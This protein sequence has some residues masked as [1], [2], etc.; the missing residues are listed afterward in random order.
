MSQEIV[1]ND[2]FTYLL[3]LPLFLLVAMPAAAQK[4]GLNSGLIPGGISNI[5]DYRPFESTNQFNSRFVRDSSYVYEAFIADSIEEWLLT[6]RTLHYY[7]IEGAETELV[8]SIFNGER[9]YLSE[10][11]EFS[12]RS[13]KDLEKTLINVWS[14]DLQEW[15][16]HEQLTYNYT[17]EGKELEVLT[18]EWTVD[19][20][21]A[22]SL[23][24][25]FYGE[26]NNLETHITSRW[27]GA[28]LDWVPE[29][30][31][32]Y[33]YEEDSDLPKT[34]RLQTWS[35]SL[36]MWINEIERT[37][38]YDEDD[39]IIEAL[40]STW[41]SNFGGF[42]PTIFTEWAYNSDGQQSDMFSKPMNESDSAD[43]GPT[44]NT[45]FYGSSAIY[46]DDG[47]LNQLVTRE[48]DRETETW[49]PIGYEKHFWSQHRSGSA[50]MTDPDITCIYANPHTIGLPWYCESLKRDTHYKFELFDITGRLYYAD[51]FMGSNTF[52]IKR[53]IPPGVYI[54]LITGG[55]DTH[56]EKVIIR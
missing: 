31:L 17:Y 5:D 55:L 41:N 13:G 25:K 14:E 47:N 3:V 32:L 40:E 30:R 10:R 7:D 43:V 15:E 21:T 2:K 28:D 46:N 38:V 36:N 45:P 51:S 24:E 22:S 6:E 48:W 33:T 34:E 23:S 37:F 54:A 42:I 12:Y 50:E 52:R 8:R 26:E 35:D 9:W 56:T 39:K 49:Q 29:E 16:K 27:S 18:E 20:W 4:V 11:L 1:M 53:N 44:Y 19:R